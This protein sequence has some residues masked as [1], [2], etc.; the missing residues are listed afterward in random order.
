MPDIVVVG[1]GGHA[2]VIISLL[3]KHGDFRIVGYTDRE[4][5]GAVLGIPWIGGDSTLSE[6]IRQ[7]P[8]CSA[9]I[10]VG[11]VGRGDRRKVLMGQ[12]GAQGFS[13]PALV[14]PTAIVN[15][16]VEIGKATV[17]FDGTVINSGTTIG[18]CVIVNTHS[19]VDHD[20]SI[21]SYVHIA[22]GA[23]LSGQVKLGDEVFLG[24]G[25]T[26]IHGVS[27]CSHCVIGA[28]AV[29]IGDCVVPGTYVG[30]PA[31]RIK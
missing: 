10:G 4:N 6:L 25:V 3:K 8:S 24:T 9:A 1:G 2:K 31:R 7:D 30:V 16:S 19:T 18:E 13:L 22:P 26:V 27:I 12:L 28:G 23:T 29:V 14:S 21:G 11:T 20:C 5:R 17:V 15:E